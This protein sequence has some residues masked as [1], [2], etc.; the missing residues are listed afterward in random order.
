MKTSRVLF[1]VL[2]LFIVTSCQ[3]IG[4]GEHNLTNRPPVTE[5]LTSDKKEIFVNNEVIL[6][7]KETDPDNDKLTYIWTK[8]G[9][10]IQT[11]R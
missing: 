1:V 6:E 11:F 10:S 2:F 4:Q 5:S 3:G 9:G 7:C 8:T